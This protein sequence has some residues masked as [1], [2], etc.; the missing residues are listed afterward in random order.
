MIG[1]RLGPYE[2]IEEIGRGGMATVYRA[3][4]PSI[5]RYVAVK[6]IHRAI[7]SDTKALE[8]FQ[9]EARLIARLEHPHLLPVYDY[10]GT[11]EPPYIVMRYL[12]GGTV[13][14][15]LDQTKLPII[16]VSYLM[17]QVA[18][19][20]DYAHRLGVIHRD[21]KPSN[22][23]I[24]Q[25][26]NAFLMDF[27][28]AR[29]A[30]SSSEG[31]TQTGF[32]VGTPGYMAPE[33]G[34]GM[35]NIDLRADI[36]SLG[37]MV[38]QMLTSKMPYQAETP[39]AIV[40][41]HI[42]DPVPSIRQLDDAIPESLDLAIAKA[43]AKKPE[44]R[45]ASAGDFADEI[46][47][48]VGRMSTP[49]LRPDTLRIAARTAVEEIHR[50]RSENQAQID[51][52]ML[53]FEQS[54][55]SL[56]KVKPDTGSTRTDAGAAPPEQG[57]RTITG[58]AGD[59]PTLITPTDQKV[60][61]PGAQRTP[62]PMPAPAPGQRPITS[63]MMPTQMETPSP[64]VGAPAAGGR[65]R[66]PLIMG[67]VA[68][69]VA[70]IVLIG[71]LLSSRP[72]PN[73]PLTETA[74]FAVGTQAAVAAAQQTSQAAI[75]S[76]NT[77]IART[78][79]QRTA[80]AAGQAEA[81]MNAGATLTA[82]APLPTG[83]L[84]ASDTP[85]PSNTTVPTDTQVVS[86][87]AGGSTAVAQA[88]TATETPRPSETPTATAT[89][90]PTATDT[91]AP[92]DT[93][94]PTN[95]A[96][97]A[98]PIVI[99]QRQL[100]VRVGPSSQYPPIGPV[101]ATSTLTI[102][103]ISDDFAWLQVELADGTIG[104]LAFN[105]QF[106]NTFG[107]LNDVPIAEPPTNTPTFTF[108]PSETP[109]PTDT[110]TNTPTATDTPT[111]TPQPTATLRPSDTPTEPPTATFTETPIPTAT[112]T[113]TPS[114]TPTDLPTAT[115]TE[116]PT[117]VPPTE[118]P[119]PV[120]PTETP[121]PTLTPTE[122]AT[123][124]PTPPPNGAF[125]FLEDFEGANPAAEWDFD[126]T[127]WQIITDGSEH[128]LSGQ[129]S[130]RQP[131]IIM[132]GG[133]Q[134]WTESQGVIINFRIFL[135]PQQV[136]ARVVFNYDESTGQYRAL[137]M[138]PGLISL[139]RNSPT[140]DLFTRETERIMQTISAPLRA[141]QW[142]DVSIW[143]QGS[144]INVY[145]DDVLLMSVNDVITPS[146]DRGQIMLQT[147]SQTRP[148]RFDDFLIQEP[149]T[150]A[151]NFDA[152]VVPDNW[153][154]NSDSSLVT[155]QSDGSG[156]YL[157]LAQGA[158][159]TLISDEPLAD[160]T[161]LCSVWSDNGG[162]SIALRDGVQGNVLL[163]ANGG[164]LA[165][166]VN[167]PNGA[168]PIDDVANFYNRGRWE[169]I[170]IEFIGSNLK[171]DRDG[172]NRWEGNVTGAPESGMVT[173]S[174]PT[175]NDIM[176]IDYCVTAPA[177]QSSNVAARPIYAL[178][179]LANSR[180]WRFLRSD[181]DE[182]FDEPFRTDDYWVDGISAAGTFTTDPN[183]AEHRQFLRMQHSGRPTW[184]MM[185]DVMG[186]EVFESG[187]SLQRST[188]IYTTVVVRFPTGS[189]GGTAWLAARTQPTLT[190]A[191][192]EGYQLGLRRNADG[193]TDVIIT[194]ISSTSQQVLFEGPA[195]LP[196]GSA[197]QP[198]WIPIEILT[199][200]NLVAYFVNGQLVFSHDNADKLGGTVALGVEPG[201]TADFDSFII[202]DTSPHDES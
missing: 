154:V 196:V 26:G 66:L 80:I 44:D 169:L 79:Q 123:A 24:D 100:I 159:V 140:P 11:H 132:G 50:R 64:A 170:F 51:A 146:I 112:F 143:Q 70:A 201:T 53:E 181:F 22:I 95:T 74:T 81:T 120:P 78:Q 135:D 33:Q 93:P 104:W 4:Q 111:E 168:I 45:F 127:A 25:D 13:K 23:M 171:I 155:V 61:V 101:D 68:A 125:P 165:I 38:Y 185:R 202:R 163:A 46:T 136:G 43:M 6:V 99:P 56:T 157:R 85:A 1:T 200:D 193:S 173:F 87:S 67:G 187:S 42:N 167:D 34:M 52:T 40:M 130:L 35:D 32:A 128:Y 149:S 5:G 31:L 60:V 197:T 144:R 121:L 199:L 106:I 142:Y 90:T 172:V 84:P 69:A 109:L 164:N 119:T 7:S 153:R 116:T 29:M 115:P 113:D 174:T 20:L 15:I 139:K 55:A 57:T 3:Y 59:G 17:R 177:A 189:M 124:A 137:E 141:S 133:F 107:N 134:P 184:R 72:D 103:G 108:T 129:G 27:G 63:D 98:T 182:N 82:N 96:T 183:A 114:A 88:A 156:N 9:R 77:S 48:A 138:F 36:Y 198:D 160:F 117:P 76:E 148:I 161:M 58:P 147:T 12:E 102:L 176:R 122:A 86:T 178:R 118:T 19:A 162:Y 10:D 18:S 2:I 188:D 97:P 192:L 28:I 175:S 14:E 65:S 151:T 16:D 166:T 131:A 180:P 73:A 54:R 150:T 92:T 30:A 179:D 47:R 126:P 39:L 110:P 186:V 195:P 145:L 191:A 194:D 75:A 94:L 190:G 8:R 49:N 21:I 158:S 91:P 62:T 105:T 83:V 71:L 37:V 89:F 152:G 41:K